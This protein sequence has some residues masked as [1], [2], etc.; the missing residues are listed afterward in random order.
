M[1]VLK[2]GSCTDLS[3]YPDHIEFTL[4][5]PPFWYE[6]AQYKQI[7]KD[8]QHKMDQIETPPPDQYGIWWGEMCALIQERMPQGGW[9][10]Y[11]ADSWTAK[12]TWPIS[13]SYFQYSSEVIWDKIRIGVG[14]YIRPRHE[15]IE[16]YRIEGIKPY[17]KY[18]TSLTKHNQNFKS[19]LK[20]TSVAVNTKSKTHGGSRGI[21]FESIIDGIPN[22]NKGV[23]GEETTSQDDHINRTP[24]QLWVPFIDYMCPKEGLVFDP[25]MGSGS[26]LEAVLALN[27]RGARRHYWGIEVDPKIYHKTIREFK[28]RKIEFET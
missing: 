14:V 4:F 7:R 9:M 21:A 16:V 6:K 24:W 5:D 17:W 10:C 19:L 8:T 11:K 13:S 20:G 28:R 15:Q 18:E 22:Y 26:I 3:L 25:C 1:I 12:K 2:H 27:R 23:F